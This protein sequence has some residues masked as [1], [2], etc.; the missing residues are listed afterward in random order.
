MTDNVIYADILTKLDLPPE[1]VIQN[2]PPSDQ[3]DEIVVIGF[4]KDGTQYFAA[5]KADGGA[6]LWLL[7]MAKRDLLNVGKQLI[8]DGDSS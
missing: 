5:N 4:L 1:R 2:L 8:G 7:E 6:V 3:W